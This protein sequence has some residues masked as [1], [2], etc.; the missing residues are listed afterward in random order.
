MGLVGDIVG[1]FTNGRASKAISDADI[2]AEHGVLNANTTGREDILNQVGIGRN[3]TEGAVNRATGA[4]NDAAGAGTQAIRGAV[5]SGANR[6]D[7]AVIGIGDA[8]AGANT[9]LANVYN[10]IRADNSSALDSGNIGNKT[11][12]DYATSP[13]SKFRFSYD[14]YKNDPAFQFELAKGRDAIQNSAAAQG[15]SQGGGV[16]AAL[17]ERGQGLAATHY[18]EAFNRA[19]S[20]FDTN[21]SATLANLQALIN[22]GQDANKTVATAGLNV[23]NKIS[24]NQTNQAAQRASLQE[25]LAGQGVGAETSIAGL[26][27]DAQ[28]A[29][30]GLDVGAQTTLAGQGISAGSTLADLGL[31][32][33]TNA[34]NF[35]TGA[36]NARASGILGTGASLGKGIEDL[37]GL[38][39]GA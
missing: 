34:G 7:A 3:G 36:G 23:G 8:A 14:D 28:R 6:V 29:I 38:F 31:K 25:F 4:I 16:L 27:A 30:G 32:S 22:S 21:Q 20:Q 39:A 5:T 9:T 26:N 35:A 15:L 24:D 2:A 33:A 13:D 37:A 17:Q 10:G 18:N 1:L 11:L 19:K 12:Q